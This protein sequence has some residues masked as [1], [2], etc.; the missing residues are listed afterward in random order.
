MIFLQI[1]NNKTVI[2]SSFWIATVVPVLP[3]IFFEINSHTNNTS[4]VT[5]QNKGYKHR[6]SPSKSTLSL[7]ISL[8]PGPGLSLPFFWPPT[9]CVLHYT[10][11]SVCDHQFDSLLAYSHYYPLSVHIQETSP[12]YR[13]AEATCEDC[14]WR[15]VNKFIKIT[16][17]KV[18]NSHSKGRL[19]LSIAFPVMITLCNT[20]NSNF[21]HYLNSP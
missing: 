17:S 5:L 4:A 20:G 18:C 19:D 3:F 15:G 11:Y 8:L 1:V 13:I 10:S 7:L 2:H 21:K 9:T 16:S 12:K 14:F 6:H